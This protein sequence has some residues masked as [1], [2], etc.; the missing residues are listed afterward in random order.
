MYQPE[1]YIAALLCMT[2]SMLCW[3][4]WANTVKLVPR[5]PFH[6]FYWDYCGGLLAASLLWG[7]TLG[8]LGGGPESFLASLQ[9]AG[10]THI[11]YAL[12]GGVIFNAANLLLVAAIAIAGMA[13]AFPVAIGLALVIGVLLNFLLSPQGNP[14]MLFGG[15][16]L[17]V[18]AILV[19]AAAYRLR[20]R[21]KKSVSARGLQLSVLSGILMGLFYPFV[22]QAIR[23]TGAL[24]PYSVNFVF[25]LG[26]LACALVMN[27]WL[28][29][30]PLS[31]EAPI[32]LHEYWAAP[33]AA[34]GAGILG[35]IIWSTGAVLSFAAS[36]AHFVGPAISYAIGQGAT[37]VSAL[38]GVFIWKEFAGAPPQSKRLVPIMFL[39]FVLGLATIA[40]APL[41][42]H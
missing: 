34:H 37:M 39:F 7:F 36:N 29:R 12:I 42:S 25:T 9:G 16:A 33:A 40:I 3:G 32:H 8:S 31:G 13:V 38:W 14:W 4:S 20:E 28:M 17:V 6:L 30:R 19:D 11:A 26:V 15:L 35:G 24:G 21:E 2:G 41:M 1:S 22:A 27:A 5:Y 23:G 18:V 10:T